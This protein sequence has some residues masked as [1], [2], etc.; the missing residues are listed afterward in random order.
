MNL[1][2]NFQCNPS[3][4]FLS[5]LFQLMIMAPLVLYPLYFFPK[6][7]LFLTFT[8]INLGLFSSIGP[9]IF[10]IKPYFL[11]RNMD[12]LQEIT[13]SFAWYHIATNMYINSYF[14]GI[15]FGYLATKDFKIKAKLR[16][17][18]WVLI[19]AIII[20]VFMWNNTFWS[21]NPTFDLMDTLLWFAFGKFF[22]SIC[23][24]GMFFMCCSGNGGKN[25]K[26]TKYLFIYKYKIIKY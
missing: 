23:F 17:I 1:L 25:I 22:S 14:V 9:A 5:A 26:F 11:Y 21:L 6:I 18:L 10:H 20:V 19:V 12:S 7:G 8:A 15:L 2:L 16:I 3:T 24:G 13:S 4:W